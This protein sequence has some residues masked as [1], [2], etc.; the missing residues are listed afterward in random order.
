MRVINQPPKSNS[1][2]VEHKDT[3]YIF[4]RKKYWKTSVLKINIK[5][6]KDNYKLVM[7]EIPCYSTRY[8]NLSYF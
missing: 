7:I 5:Q 2:M 8:K 3:F 1:I 4:H 6:W